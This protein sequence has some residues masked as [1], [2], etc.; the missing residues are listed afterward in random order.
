MAANNLELGGPKEEGSMIG[1]LIS[2]KQL[3]RVMGYLDEGK[4]DG[5]EGESPTVVEGLVVES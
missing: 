2:Q 5:V 1:P 3:P 4:S